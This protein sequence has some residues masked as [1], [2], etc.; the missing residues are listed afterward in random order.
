MRKIK[1]RA[2]NAKTG[3]WVYT[4]N[5]GSDYRLY[6]MGKHHARVY[7]CKYNED[8]IPTILDVIELDPNTICQ[9][10]GFK[11]ANSKEIYEGDIITPKGKIFSKE[12]KY[13]VAWN[14][15]AG[16][17]VMNELETDKYS[18]QFSSSHLVYEVIG[19]I[20]DNLDG[21][22]PMKYSEP[23]VD[24][25]AM[26]APGSRMRKKKEKPTWKQCVLV[27]LIVTAFAIWPIEWLIFKII[28]W[29]FF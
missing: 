14:Q 23:E 25:P 22:T 7:V 16:A 17:Y 15:S 21:A 5:G 12:R 8:P 10:T 28:K 29:L 3:E 20:Y 27:A 9:Y 26:P 18:T 19:N 24:I 2:K 11:D 4:K 1:F 6:R 13:V